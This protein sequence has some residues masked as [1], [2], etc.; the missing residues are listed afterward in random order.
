MFLERGWAEFDEDE[1]EEHDW[2]LWWKTSRFRINEHDQVMPWQ[3][4]N[5]YPVSHAITK[6]DFLARNLKR[7]KTV[8]GNNYNFSPVA[9]N[10]PNDYTKFVSEYTRLYDKG[11]MY[12]I[13][14]P[15]DMSR[16]RGIFIFKDLSE[17][18]YDCNAVVQQYIPNPLLIS[19][20]KFDL[21]IYVLVSSFHPLNIYIYNEGL[22]RF[23]TEKFDL[24]SLKNKYSHLTN[25]SINKNSPS[26]ATDKERVGPGCKWTLTQFRH[27]LHQLGVDDTPLF[28]KIINIVILT[29]L[30]QAQT[31]P[32]VDHCFELYGFDIIIDDHWKPWLL[33]VNFSPAMSF[34]CHTDLC[35]KK[36][37]IHDLCDVLKFTEK[38]K[39][40]GGLDYQ[41]ERNKAQEMND[42]LYRSY[43]PQSYKST[44]RRNSLKAGN[45]KQPLKKQ[46]SSHKLPSI[47][48]GVG[49]ASPRS[50]S[51]VVGSGSPRSIQDLTKA[52]NNNNI[53]CSQLPAGTPDQV[54]KLIP[55]CGLPS[56][57][58][59]HNM[60]DKVDPDSGHCS[61]ANTGA[62][63]DKEVTAQN[64]RKKSGKSERR[65]TSS[66]SNG[67][68]HDDQQRCQTGR[69]RKDTMNASS[70]QTN[71]SD[72]G[73]STHSGS[74]SG[75]H[76]SPEPPA[77]DTERVSAK[78]RSNS[79]HNDSQHNGAQSRAVKAEEGSVSSEVSA[80]SPTSQQKYKYG[81]IRKG[82]RLSM[83]SRDFRNPRKKLN[84]SQ[85]KNN[86]MINHDPR[87]LAFRS[88]SQTSHRTSLVSSRLA[89]EM[90][91]EKQT[92]ARP[93]RQS[94]AKLQPDNDISMHYNP[95]HPEK[96]IGEFH[97][98]FPFN[99]PT[100]RTSIGQLDTKII[101]KECQK[102]L[103][104][105]CTKVQQQ[106]KQ[107]KE[108][109]LKSAKRDEGN[110]NNKGSN[111]NLTLLDNTADKT[112]ALS[113]SPAVTSAVKSR[114][115]TSFSLSRQE[116]KSATS[117]GNRGKRSSS[118]MSSNTRLNNK[119]N[120]ATVKTTNSSTTPALSPTV[121]GTPPI[122]SQKK[123][124]EQQTHYILTTSKKPTF[125]T[126]QFLDEP[127][128]LWGPLR[129]EQNQLSF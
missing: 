8:Y 64:N 62:D 79:H 116:V 113:A 36:P 53:R 23:S 10:L 103:K 34:D 94:P 25:T 22:V 45:K 24:S 76:L 121:I 57:Q 83:L 90:P 63:C 100:H 122:S 67:Q 32:K 114:P 99:D 108:L 89:P 49:G 30:I 31:A 104:E 74:S 58:Q 125:F 46:S 37:L 82:E 42:T 91:K 70:S 55:G 38:D 77:G 2:N 119:S 1:Q 66:V 39:E 21:R 92:R 51:T 98:V 80:A 54:V 69:R 41:S 27:Y 105:R 88:Q 120:T 60:V 44:T 68:G 85:V 59:P 124:A 61:P 7:M 115:S 11:I 107:K 3:R 112:P 75:H 123:P 26:Y 33:E 47:S 72:S 9:F 56:V 101:I 87:G 71:V 29:I 20:Y 18:Q 73:V 117:I 13:C 15:A 110:S 5:H 93:W 86:S 126:N 84:K 52:M 128:E 129:N 111:S 6:K 78:M 4:L 48:P 14:K 81:T 97:L 106:K 50:T 35:V 102:L 95:R 16:G 40:R 109:L 118:R 43:I 96:V 127:K 19:G 12:W 28:G 17:L 65:E